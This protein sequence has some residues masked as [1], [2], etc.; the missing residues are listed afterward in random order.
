MFTLIC[1]N[2][3]SFFL[4]WEFTLP[5]A[6]TNII[7]WETGTRFIL[8]CI[9][10]SKQAILNRFSTW[11]AY[12]TFWFSRQHHDHNQTKPIHPTLC[13]MRLEELDHT[14]LPSP[15]LSDSISLE[16]LL[17][18]RGESNFKKSFRV[19]VRPQVWIQPE[20]WACSQF[21]MFII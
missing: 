15:N 9:K 7:D 4:Y 14:N 21:I 11:S 10:H 17:F 20:T 6:K 2:K 1:S 13:S 12:N 16:T 3:A 8:S 5:S 18:N 19:W